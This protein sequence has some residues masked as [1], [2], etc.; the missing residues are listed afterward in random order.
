[1]NRETSAAL[2]YLQSQTVRE[3]DPSEVILLRD[4]FRLVGSSLD[5]A[6]KDFQLVHPITGAPLRKIDDID[7]K[8]PPPPD[9]PDYRR[10]CRFDTEICVQL[11]TT[12]SKL[13]AELG[14]TLEMTASACAVSLFRRRYLKDKVP[15]H[16]HL[17][18][19]RMICP[20]CGLE[21]C[22]RECGTTKGLPAGKNFER[23]QRLLAK[24]KKTPHKLCPTY[25]VGCFHFAALGKNG[26]RH[27]GHVD[28]LRQRLEAGRCYDV[29]SL[30]P[31]AMLGPVPT[32]PMQRYVNLTPRE[33]KRLKP[34]SALALATAAWDLQ[35]KTVL[36]RAA[37]S[38]E[39]R[40]IVGRH[41]LEMATLEATFRVG[42]DHDPNDPN[43][44]KVDSFERVRRCGYVEAIVSIPPADKV[45]E[46]YFPPLPVVRDS[47]GG[48]ILFWPVGDGIYGWWCYEE[49]R[50][51]LEVPG[52]RLVALRQSVWFRG[53]PLFREFVETLYSERQ[54]SDGAKKQLLK[55]L[56]NSTY[57]KTLQNP[58]KRRVIRLQSTQERPPGWLPTNPNPPDGDD[59]TWPWGTIQEYREAP[60]FLPHWGSL[61]TAR[62]RIVLWRLCMI[63][64][65]AGKKVAYTDTDSLYTDATL[66]EDAKKLGMLKLEYQLPEDKRKK[67]LDEVERA[68]INYQKQHAALVAECQ[69]N[70][71]L[72]PE[73]KNTRIKRLRDRLRYYRQD[74]YEYERSEPKYQNARP[75]GLITCEFYGPKLYIVADPKTGIEV[76]TVHKGSP[77]PTAEKLRKFIQGIALPNKP[78]APKAGVGIR[79]DFV[80]DP[81]VLER[82]GRKAL[83]K[84]AKDGREIMHKRI[85]HHDPGDR[86]TTSPRFISAHEEFELEESFRDRRLVTAAALYE[87]WTGMPWNE[88][89]G[90]TGASAAE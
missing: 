64:E 21:T 12:F 48:E 50:A 87:E 82:T 38:G 47:E 14:G 53:E 88:R 43:F 59:F 72:T 76:K 68:W 39:W 63:V 77:E 10:Y 56:L 69:D 3:P 34:G 29:N 37:S 86:G 26:H 66:P 8:N 36:E 22:S 45:P 84:K 11:V 62:A 28:V 7:V 70:L 24:H 25:P 51:L 13:I 23:H 52:A 67:H 5:D 1:M 44:D 90:E 2:R 4:S 58:L 6:A 30:Y 20:S 85:H 71:L 9:D 18:G 73:E 46:C 49:L 55:I 54:K 78:K 16:R 17:T 27:G 75:E 35:K 79:D 89:A 41:G 83:W 32:G 81:I 42:A 60:F 74:I 33:K 31:F 65:R 61:I 80:F 19:C 15:R 57:G 40:S